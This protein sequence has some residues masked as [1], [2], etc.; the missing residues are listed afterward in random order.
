MAPLI[1]LAAV[2]TMGLGACG[3][4]DDET[5]TQQTATTAAPRGSDTVTIEMSDYAYTVSGPLN[6]GGTLRI[7]NP[8]K[9]FHVLAMGRFRPGKTL[10]DLQTM[11]QQLA[12]QGG[13]GGGGGGE[14]TTTTARGGT[15]TTARGGTTTTAR[16][17]TTTTSAAGGGQEQDPF[18]EI[19]ESE[20]GVPGG[21]MSPGESVEVTVPN[22]QPGTYGLICFI[23]TEVEG[24]PHFAKGMVNQLEVVA[25]PTPPQ[26]TADA[27][28][29]LAPGQAVQGPATLT[30]GRHTLKFEGAPGSHQLEP[31]LAR[32]NAGT[33]ATQFYN[34][35]M[36]LF[37]S[38]DQP[39]PRN[40]ASQVPGQ[41]VYAG[42]DLHDA[43]TFYLTVDLRPGSYA[44]IAEDSDPEDRPS[45]PREIINIRVA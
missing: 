20:M 23:P 2:M 44:I 7:S 18:A 19:F 15:T 34:A 17:G 16:G 28:Y 37:E 41:I 10:Q 4:D 21:F 1:A 27:T 11:L 36:R 24:T 3:D 43:T 22:L 32:L 12:Q 38:E 8:G 35:L 45:P 13:P 25:G 9:E 40:A 39:P 33:S 29:R 26:P 42:L 5:A 6:A 14:A 31:G 30:P